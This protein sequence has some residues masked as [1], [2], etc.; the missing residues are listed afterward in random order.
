MKISIIIPVYNAEEC[1]EKCIDSII[2]QTYKDWELI[3]VDD[4]SIDNS[5]PLCKKYVAI[6]SRIKL[7]SKQNGGVSKARN[8]G[9]DRAQG[10]YLT[11][12]DADDY[13]DI[14]FLSSLLE[15]QSFDFVSLSHRRFGKENKVMSLK[16]D[17]SFELP[18]GFRNIISNKDNVSLFILYPWAK[19]FKSEIIKQYNIRFCEEIKL[20]EDSLFVITYLSC[21]HSAIFKRSV[22]YNYYITE[23]LSKKYTFDYNTYLVHKNTYHKQLAQIKDKIDIVDF[24]NRIQSIY[25]MNYFDYL[26][27]AKNLSGHASLVEKISNIKKMSRIFSLTGHKKAIMLYINYLIKG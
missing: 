24:E 27:N 7:F 26:L 23:S 8:F 14:N 2:N 3:I 12:I 22:C 15:C 19:L 25:L 20:A 4:G 21:C 13:V 16:N 17:V 10:Q 1:I 6:D 9:M 5:L 11:F 18:A